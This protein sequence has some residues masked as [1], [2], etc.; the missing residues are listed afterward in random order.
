MAFIAYPTVASLF[1]SLTRY[2]LL[3]QPVFIGLGNYEQLFRDPLMGTAIKN[4][5]YYMVIS[6][7]LNIVVSILVALLLNLKVKGMAVYRTLFYMPSLVPPVATSL[8]WVWVLNPQ[9]GVVN[10]LLSL[11]GIAGPWW[12]ASVTWSKPAIILISLWGGLGGGMILFLASLQD[13]PQD[14][15]DAALVD[16]ANAWQRFWA[17]VLPMLTPVVFYEL[18]LGIIGG[19]QYFVVPYVVTGG[20]GNPANSLTLFAVLLYRDAF[21]NFKMG[22]ASAM[23]WS[24]MVVIFALTF[25]VFR[26]S[27]RWVFYQ[28]GEAR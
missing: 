28:S 4:T 8:L 12:L 22:Y 13:V 2:D 25:V 16:G 7:P 15:R 1:Y 5:V 19:F 23:A 20:T 6:I 11:V 14:V 9:Y 27:N 18:I 3:Q 21:F 17:I 24:A 26:T 10:W